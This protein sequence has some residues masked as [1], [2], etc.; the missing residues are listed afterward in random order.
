MAPMPPLSTPLGAALQ[1]T[2]SRHTGHAYRAAGAPASLGTPATHTEQRARPPPYRQLCAAA[3]SAICGPT[4]LQ[5]G[6]WA[7]PR[8]TGRSEGHAH[9]DQFDPSGAPGC[10]ADAAHNSRLIKLAAAGPQSV[11]DVAE[12]ICGRWRVLEGEE[13]E[14]TREA[15]RGPSRCFAERR[16]AR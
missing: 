2:R 4:E 8:R 12:A 11:T 6:R 14:F 13:R 16:I 7:S 5:S 9:G 10:R 3:Q 1:E 15:S